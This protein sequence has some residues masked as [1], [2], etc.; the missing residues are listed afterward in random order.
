M[1]RMEFK[2]FNGET[3]NSRGSGKER[4]AFGR[5]SQ[6]LDLY[7]CTHDY[8]YCY[9]NCYL[10]ISSSCTRSKSFSRCL[11]SNSSRSS[12]KWSS[13]EYRRWLS[14]S[15]SCQ[16]SPFLAR[17]NASWMGEEKDGEEEEEDADD[18]S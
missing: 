10:E 12:V 4:R 2:K 7:Y 11:R 6:A 8:S 9:H 3:R 13:G 5:Q 17:S 1:D 15:V 14:F 16:R 18:D